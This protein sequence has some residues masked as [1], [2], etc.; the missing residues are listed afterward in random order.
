MSVTILSEA[1]N[2]SLDLEYLAVLA[3]KFAHADRLADL[4]AIKIQNFAVVRS[5]AQ[6]LVKLLETPELEENSKL[7]QQIRVCLVAL[8]NELDMMESHSNRILKLKEELEA[9]VE[10]TWAIAKI[11]D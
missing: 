7:M 4:C 6:D 9:V 5:R 8:E 1:M 10:E 11:P 2:D 3:E